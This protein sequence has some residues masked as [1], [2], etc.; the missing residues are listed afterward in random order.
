MAPS[1]VLGEASATDACV[2][3]D[4]HVATDGEDELLSLQRNLTGWRKDERLG[5]FNRRVELLENG[6]A[7]RRG[8]VHA[9]LSLYDHIMTLYHGD[10]GTPLNGQWSIETI[11]ID[12]TKELRPQVH[13]IKAVDNPIPI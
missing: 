7:N 6:Y 8:L 10:D 5:P 13:V 12:A 11:F 4:I 1:H 3:I 2:T 9:G